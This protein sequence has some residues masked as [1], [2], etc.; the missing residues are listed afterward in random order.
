MDRRSSFLPALSLPVVT[1][2]LSQLALIVQT[3][4]VSLNSPSPARALKQS[5]EC[6]AHQCCMAFG[7]HSAAPMASG[8]LCLR[9]G[10]LG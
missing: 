3:Q 7:K 4:I 5:E 8:Y 6:A 2:L 9:Q 10:S 1:L